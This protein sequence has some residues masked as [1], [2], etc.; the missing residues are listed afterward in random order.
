[1]FLRAIRY[2]THWPVGIFT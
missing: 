2:I 1:M